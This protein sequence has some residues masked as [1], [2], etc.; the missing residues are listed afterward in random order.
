M[1]S[2]R[3]RRAPDA[4][5]PGRFECAAHCQARLPVRIRAHAGHRVRRTFDRRRC[6]QIHLAGSRNVSRDLQHVHAPPGQHR[7]RQ[8]LRQRVAHPPRAHQH[9]RLLPSGPRHRNILPFVR[10]LRLQLMEIPAHVLAVTGRQPDQHSRPGPGRLPYPTASTPC[11]K[12]CETASKTAAA[13]LPDT[14]RRSHDLPSRPARLPLYPRCILS[15]R[16]PF[17]FAPRSQ[18]PF[19]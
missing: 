12:A 17:R 2:A 4:V 13:A 10:D 7:H 9:D 18:Y 11:A 5:R 14:S 3:R 19:A 16:R 6:Q 15:T 8:K 1:S